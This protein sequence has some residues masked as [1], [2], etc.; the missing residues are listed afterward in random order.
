MFPS[1]VLQPLKEW[2]T[3]RA[4]DANGCGPPGS[5]SWTHK[6]E[7]RQLDAEVQ[8]WPTPAAILINDAE[9]PESFHARAARWKEE[10]GYNNT[11]P[12]VI[13]VKGTEAPTARLNPEFVEHLMGWPTGWTGLP[14][15]V[16]GRLAAES[17]KKSGKARASRK[18]KPTSESAG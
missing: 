1:A 17:R 16:F 10:K 14:P 15:E 18:K 9:S 2:S 6:M 8:T 7:R 3:P 12:L 11:V 13:A 5:K 4:A